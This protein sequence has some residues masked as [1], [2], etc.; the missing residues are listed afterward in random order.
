[1]ERK[2]SIMDTTH[3]DLLQLPHYLG[4]LI[5]FV[6]GE[7]DPDPSQQEQ[8][9][10][11]LAMCSYCRIALIELLFAE[12]E[13]EKKLNSLLE[14]SIRDVLMQFVTIHHELEARDYEQIAAYAEAILTE[15]KE[16]TDKRFPWLAEHLERCL[17]CRSTLAEMLTFL[18]EGEKID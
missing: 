6:A 8:L 7:W 15:K 4:E 13:H 1:M 2:A 12:Q 5:R 10:T 9:V 16:E 18:R 11:H 17:V 14:V 3:P